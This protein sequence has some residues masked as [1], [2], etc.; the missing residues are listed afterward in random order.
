MGEIVLEADHLKPDELC[1][2]N[3]NKNKIT[4]DP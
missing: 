2:R 4:V 1:T 3:T